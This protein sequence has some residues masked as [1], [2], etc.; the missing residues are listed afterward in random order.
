MEAEN[1]LVYRDFIE[2]VWSA[3]IFVSV[4]VN[5]AGKG[6]GNYP[7]SLVFPGTK[8]CSS[9]SPPPI[10]TKRDVYFDWLR[11]LYN[12]TP[13]SSSTSIAVLK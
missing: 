2:T 4:M 6:E 13:R 5:R 8:T 3:V 7:M 1:G 9:V 12:Y 10:R 11:R